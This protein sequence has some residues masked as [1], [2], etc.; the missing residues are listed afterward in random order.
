VPEANLDPWLPVAADLA[1][2]LG[3]GLLVGLQRERGE[4]RLAGIRTFALTTV[5]GALMAVLAG[6][7]GLWTVAVGLLALAA[8][9]VVGNVAKLRA[10]V[11]DPGLT[12]EVALLVMYGVGAYVVG[13]SHALAIVASGAVTFLLFLKPRLHGWVRGLDDDDF[14][15][16]MRFAL[17]S[18]V[19]LPILPDRTFGPYDVLNPRSIWWMVVLI[20]GLGLAGYLAFRWL[21]QR[22][23][24]LAAGLLGGLISSTATSV[25]Y[26]RQSR[27]QPE[28]SRLGSF[29]VV[30]ASAVVFARL[31][32]EIAVVAPSFLAAAAL[33]LLA[34]L[35]ACLAAAAFAWRYHREGTA[36]VAEPKNPSELKPALYFGL[37]YGGVLLAVAAAKEHFG[38]AG[39]YAVAVISGLTDMDAITLGTAR[40]VAQGS[41]AEDAGWRVVVVASLANLGFKLALLTV[42]GDRS[43]AR[44]VAVAFAAVGVTGAALL[45]LL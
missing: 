29:V 10:G 22:G 5:F 7:Y 42:L 32:V 30:L 20:V 25:A 24:A 4:S 28:T 21:G 23:G 37:L 1:L 41:L 15:A 19:I 45:L 12:T 43:L 2:A 13:G 38:A 26:A 34:L 3:L 27:A 40:L 35:G 36:I 14:A 8:L 31:L 9:L 16:I 11:V 6:R 44:R 39:L 33:P 18:L 17:I